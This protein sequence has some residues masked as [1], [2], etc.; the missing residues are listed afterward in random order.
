MK[1]LRKVGKEPSLASRSDWR[2]RPPNGLV[3][4]AWKRRVRVNLYRWPPCHHPHFGPFL[5]KKCRELGC[6]RPAAN[7]GHV[8]PLELM[9][10]NVSGAVR[11]EIIREGR[12]LRGDMLEMTKPGGNHHV[13]RRFLFP[14]AQPKREFASA[15][16]KQRNL[17]VFQIGNE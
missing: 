17:L 12:Q 9:Q 7:D 11:Q 10:V 14:V 3:E 5:L 4:A 1:Y 2:H 15:S 8:A 13:A 16:F 6:R